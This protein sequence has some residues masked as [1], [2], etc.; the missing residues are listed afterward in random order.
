MARVTRMELRDIRVVRH[1]IGDCLFSACITSE[2]KV[3][4]GT[5]VRGFFNKSIS[6]YS[7]FYSF[8]SSVL[9]RRDR[10]RTLLPGC[11]RLIG[12]DVLTIRSLRDSARGYGTGVL[13]L[14]GRCMRE[15]RVC[16]GVV[17]SARKTPTHRQCTIAGDGGGF[18][19]SSL[20]P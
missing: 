20:V 8:L 9:G 2:N 12:K 17:R 19:G 14:G 15:M 6:S 3:E 11:T 18:I 1:R 4:I 13:G 7:L 16:S 10:C 5:A